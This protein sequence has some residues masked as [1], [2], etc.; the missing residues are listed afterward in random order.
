MLYESGRY[1]FDTKNWFRRILDFIKLWT[2]T[3]QY[4]LARLYSDINR[5]KFYGIQP[6]EQNVRR[7][8]NI[9]GETGVNMEVNGYTF[10]TLTQ[11]KQFDD[12]VKSLIYAFF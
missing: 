12:I 5:G 2:R 6:S 8:R 3:G 11:V 7:F 10:K 9:Y 1:A 4:A